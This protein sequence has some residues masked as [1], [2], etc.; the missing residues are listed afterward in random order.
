MTLCIRERRDTDQPEATTAGSDLID[1]I[2]QG[3]EK[4]FNEETLKKATDQLTTF[5]NKLKVRFID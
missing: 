3:F 1:Q 2:R 5:G 4:T